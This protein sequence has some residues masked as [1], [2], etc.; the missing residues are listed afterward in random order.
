MGSEKIHQVC[1][2]GKQIDRILGPGLQTY[3]IHARDPAW[4]GWKNQPQ[5]V[6]HIWSVWGKH[7]IAFGTDILYWDKQGNHQQTSAVVQYVFI[8]SFCWSYFH[9][10]KSWPM[11]LMIVRTHL[12]LVQGRYYRVPFVTERL[13]YTWRLGEGEAVGSCLQGFWKLAFQNGDS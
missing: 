9:T 13:S 10:D 12:L 2:L 8:F 5:L 11:A 6:H 7:V 1:F 3:M 4:V